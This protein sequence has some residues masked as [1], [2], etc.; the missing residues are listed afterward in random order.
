MSDWSNCRDQILR[1]AE[2]AELLWSR[3]LDEGPGSLTEQDLAP[4]QSQLDATRQVIDAIEEKPKWIDELVLA[5]NDAEELLGRCVRRVEGL[6]FVTGEAGLIPRRDLHDRCDA[7]LQT[8]RRLG[9]S[10]DLN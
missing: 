7:A 9:E 8:M 6:S 3:Y 4:F 1:L 10:Q 5:T 2:S